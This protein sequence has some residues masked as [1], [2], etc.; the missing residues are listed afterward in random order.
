MTPLVPLALWGWPPAV[1]WLYSK[2][3][4]RRAA[5]AGFLLAWMFLPQYS[6]PFPG[7]PKYGKIMAACAGILLGTA[8]F[9]SERFS[10]FQFRIID[11]P[12]VLWCLSPVMAS[13]TNDLGLYDGISAMKN[14]VME[15]AFPYYIGRLYFRDLASL[16]EL[17]IGIFLGGVF[18]SPFCL[19]EMVISPQLHNIAYGFHPAE[20]GQSLRGGGYRP[21]VFMAHGLMVAMWMVSACLTG[22]TLLKHQFIPTNLPFLNWVKP[23]WLVLGLLA[24]TVLCK[25]MGALVLLIFGLAVIVIST[26][27]RTPILV[28]VLMLIP[29]FYMTTRGTASWD[30]MNVVRFISDT[31]SADRAAS[32]QFRLENENV[33]IDKAMQ[34]PV[35]GWGGWGRSRVYNAEGRDVTITD[36][37]WIII[38]GTT[39]LFGLAGLTLIILTPAVLFLRA[40]PVSTWSIPAV[41]AAVPLAILLCLF[42]I[43]SLL[44]AM[45]SPIYMLAAGGLSSLAL[46]R[47]SGGEVKEMERPPEGADDTMRKVPPT[48]FLCLSA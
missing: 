6:Y 48:R 27:F 20:F 32:L 35:F 10:T 21:V 18:Y 15:W 1:L 41:S 44:N 46:E 45:P 30:G 42:M 25:S 47:S 9:D 40:Y 29:I 23:A 22:V 5:I 38:L 33:L 26:K 43:D 28:Y 7:L 37:Y 8:V 31:F 34:R 36:G 16:R 39:G 17:A 24:T 14:Y 13:L 3:T 19:V 4:P 2:L 12:M 11:M